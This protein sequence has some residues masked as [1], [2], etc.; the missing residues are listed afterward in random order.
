MKHYIPIYLYLALGG[1]LEELDVNEIKVTHMNHQIN[2]KP[3]KVVKI[4]SAGI[5]E[6]DNVSELFAVNFEDGTTSTKKEQGL[7][8]C[9]LMVNVDIVLKK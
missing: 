8:G 3:K 4:E 5:S 1:K 2:Y 9:F 7:H 6:R